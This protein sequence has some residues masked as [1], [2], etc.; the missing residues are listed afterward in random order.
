MVKTMR[1]IFLAALALCAAMAPALAD[2]WRDFDAGIRPSEQLVIGGQPTPEVLREAAAAGT[3]VVVNFR[4]ADEADPGYDEAALAAELG[5]TY[6]QVPVA[7]QGGLTEQNIRLFDA[8]LE[9]VGEQPA[10]MHCSTG[11][12]VGS[13][14][15][16]H[17][18]LY[19]G[20]DVDAAIEF[21]KARGLTHFEDEVRAE[22]EEVPQP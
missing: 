19:G 3:K 10:L 18:A 22:L 16:L 21:G 14:F 2:E 8:V 11:N 1:M 13:M 5:M 20:L 9:Q 12:R 17:A 6:L 4:P 15:A 7:K